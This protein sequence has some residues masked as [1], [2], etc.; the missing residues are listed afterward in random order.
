MTTQDILQQVQ[1][2]ANIRL[3]DTVGQLLA[4]LRGRHSHLCWRRDCTCDYCKFINGE[5]VSTKLAFHKL[6][7]RIRHFEYLCYLTTEEHKRVYD[8][9]TQEWVM[10]NKIKELRKRKK[11]MQTE[12]V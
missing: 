2:R 8:L 12:I 11:A 7:K 10:K 1:E 3:G 5:Y 4:I 9:N 6:K